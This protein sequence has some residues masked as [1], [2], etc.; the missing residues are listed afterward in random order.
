MKPDIPRL[1]PI[2]FLPFLLLVGLLL[3]GQCGCRTGGSWVG[4]G[5]GVK[6]VITPSDLEKQPNGTFKL[7]PKSIGIPPGNPVLPKSTEVKSTPIEIKSAVTKPAPPKPTSA[8]PVKL[9]PTNVKAAESS[10][11]FKPTITTTPKLEEKVNVKPIKNPPT[12]IN[13][14]NGNSIAGPS[15]QP[16]LKKSGIAVQWLELFMFYFLALMVAVFFWIMY[17]IFKT[18]KKEKALAK[19]KTPRK[20]AKRTKKKA[21]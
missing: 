7:K 5:S 18:R 1:V 15:E 16:P 4:G 10:T 13:E 8:E 12:E 3:M 20:T 11:P 2:W 19:K 6:Q 14:G 9:Q 21:S 17:D